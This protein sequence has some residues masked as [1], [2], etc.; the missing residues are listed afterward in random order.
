ML[1]AWVENIVPLSFSGNGTFLYP[2]SAYIK[3]TAVMLEE[4]GA[5]KLAQTGVR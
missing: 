2:F 5:V 4:R 3:K 1:L